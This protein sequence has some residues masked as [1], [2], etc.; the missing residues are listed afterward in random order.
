M[1]I[2]YALTL[3]ISAFLLFWVQLWVGKLLLP[4][5]GGAP[6]VWNTCMVFF[7][8]LLLLGYSYAHILSTRIAVRYQAIVHTLFL[9]I[10]LSLLPLSLSPVTSP[11]QDTNPIF[12]LLGIL[13]ITVGLPSLAIATTAP[14]MQRWFALAQKNNDPYFLYAASNIGSLLSLVSY[15][16]LIETN[17]SLSQQS[18]LWAGGY[19]VLAS[20]TGICAINLW[21]SAAPEPLSAIANSP[22]LENPDHKNLEHK[23][24]L[25][26]PS[27]SQQFRWIILSFLPASLLLG[28][29]TYITTDIAAVPLFWA[30]PLIVYLLTFI[31]AFTNNSLINQQF[32][33]Q[34]FLPLLPV[35]LTA[36]V[37]SFLLQ[38]MRPI[39]LLVPLHLLGL[40]FVGYICHG[41]LASDRPQP[42]YLT[43]FYFWI[44]VGGVAGGIFNAIISPLLFTSI[45]EYPSV[46]IISFLLLPKLAGAANSGIISE[47][48]PELISKL[49]ADL[50][51]VS[52]SG[53]SI[54]KSISELIPKPNSQVNNSHFRFSVP[55][56]LGL[57]LATL[58]VGF[59][60]RF[61]WSDWLGI[62]L[63]I[64]LWLG[65][66]K[67]F[68]LSKI[69]LLV[70]LLLLS[71]LGQFSLTTMG[72]VLVSDRS[73]FGIYRVVSQQQ[74]QYYSLFHGTT[75]HGKQSRDPQR[76]GEPLTYFSATGPI[77]QVFN[78]FPRKDTSQFLEK[79]LDNTSQNSHI[80]VLG[81]GVGTLFSYARSLQEWTFYE[82]D[83]VVVKL[84]TNP[85]YFSFLADNPSISQEAIKKQIILG[86]GRLQLAKA[87]DDYYDLLVMDAFSSD[88]IPTHLVTL[89]AMQLY[90]Q[91]LRK[92][93]II[94][95]NIS[96]R[97]IN[98]EPVLAKLAQEL[99][100]V[101][102][103][104]IDR[105]ITALEKEQGK[106]ASHWVIMARN[107]EYLGSLITDFPWQNM[108]TSSNSKF[109]V[110]TDDFS[111]IWQVL[112]LNEKENL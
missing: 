60:P 86:D 54:S 77:G 72:Q 91:K 18:Y 22:I 96:N 92:N 45:L 44:S 63:V 70:G 5:L 26:R 81:L 76:R 69:R 33:Y 34:K 83:P 3:F 58:I 106:T 94:A 98:L 68:S 51:N 6:G 99:G 9:L 73:F 25:D 19:G 36:L 59:S 39:A 23:N 49:T 50:T 62:I 88:A 93:G 112:K 42:N 107:Q 110:W 85:Q 109:Q 90:L 28:T 80:A 55:I 43:L 56:S 66:Y 16:V 10:P 38:L 17:F 67:T 12:W 27:K 95:V 71:L 40:F 64:M 47:L 35:I 29:T 108:S 100:L 53:E 101:S 21:K 61:F 41:E 52:N 89:E 111:D 13:V 32:N 8:A 31:L 97:F 84:A 46:L 103:S 1:V 14:L 74:G 11:P 2:I 7:Q 65:I 20:L 24:L 75:L 4:L 57:I 78:Y 48:T 79:S 82:I 30:I 37:I 15:P 102:Y 105:A 104:Q 87:K